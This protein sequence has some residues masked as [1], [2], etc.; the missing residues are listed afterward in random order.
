[1]ETEPTHKEHLLLKKIFRTNG[2]QRTTEK[3]KLGTHWEL[4]RKGYLKNLVTLPSGWRFILTDEGR[5][6]LKS[7]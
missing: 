2:E 5:E 1:M 7:N 6:Y 4:V 3:E